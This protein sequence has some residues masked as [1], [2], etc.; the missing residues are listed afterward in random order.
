MRDGDGHGCYSRFMK[1][2]ARLAAGNIALWCTFWL[3]GVPLSLVWDASGGC[4]VVGCGIGEPLIAGFFIVLFTLSSL[5]IV[6]VSVAIWRS[7]SQYPRES[8]W[9]TPLAIAAKL[10]A[11]FMG[12][13][14]TLSF[15]AV[16][17]FVASFIYAARVTS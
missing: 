9:Q 13:S 3:I 4:M 16:L 14:A 10:C 11:V 1:F 2:L 15:L 12:L 17:Y 5:A 6:F 8:W 7:S